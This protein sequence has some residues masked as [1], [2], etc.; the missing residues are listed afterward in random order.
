[1]NNKKSSNNIRNR[2]KTNI[3]D[4]DNSNVNVEGTK[5]AID[6]FETEIDDGKNEIDGK[7]EIES[8]DEVTD[9]SEDEDDEKGR[10]EAELKLNKWLG[11]LF[12]IMIFISAMLYCLWLLQFHPGWYERYKLYY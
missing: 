2:F 1:M 6:T 9:E 12:R 3:S 11:L 7:E 5:E 8:I 10:F 4:S